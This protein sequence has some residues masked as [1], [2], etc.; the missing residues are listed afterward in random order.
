MT[1]EK[2]KHHYVPQF[3]IKAFADSNNQLHAWDGD[4]VRVVGAGNIMQTPWLYTVFDAK[5]AA[6]DILENS[7]SKVEGIA[8]PVFRA[9]NDSTYV[10]SND[11]REILCMFLGLQA[12]RHPDILGRGERRSREL[13]KTI[14]DVHSYPTAGDFVGDLSS[15]GIGPIDAMAI[16]TGFMGV[17][18]TD[19]QEQLDEILNLSPQD[20]RLP[21]QDALRA[22][23]IIGREISKMTLELLEAPLGKS[24]VLGDTPMLQSDLSHGF[25][26]PLSKSVALQAKPASNSQSTVNR[27]AATTAEINAANKGHL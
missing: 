4:N 19:L 27:R 26:L 22:E 6:S 23:D 11:D 16:Y 18:P 9:A 2:N 5:W 17:S 15:F 10:L 3:W 13:A 20:A 14:A 1:I 25:I 24:F 12:C 8:A 7:L 21:A